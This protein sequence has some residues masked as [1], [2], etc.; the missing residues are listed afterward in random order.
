MRIGHSLLPPQPSA[1]AGPPLACPE[2]FRSDCAAAWQQPGGFR[3]TCLIPHRIPNIY[4]KLF[5]LENQA[6]GLRSLTLRGCSC[7]FVSLKSKA[8]EDEAHRS[9][10]SS[11]RRPPVSAC[12]AFPFKGAREGMS[13]LKPWQPRRLQTLTPVA[14][15]TGTTLAA[16]EAS[17]VPAQATWLRIQFSS[18]TPQMRWAAKPCRVVRVSGTWVPLCLSPPYPSPFSRQVGKPALGRLR[19]GAGASSR[20]TP[21]IALH[22]GVLVPAAAPRRLCRGNFEWR[23]QPARGG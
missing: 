8:K 17:P 15:E 13:V 7:P 16:V 10:G 1:P 3:V 12:S 21:R 19:C 4:F 23:P 14:T 11:S 9:P 18:V 20:A 22:S 5:S 6:A 2:P